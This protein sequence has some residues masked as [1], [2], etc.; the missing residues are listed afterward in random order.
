[1]REEDLARA[2]AEYLRRERFNLKRIEKNDLYYDNLILNNEI[3]NINKEYDYKVYK[4]RRIYDETHDE[5]RMPSR[6]TYYGPTTEEMEAARIR[7]M[8]DDT[9]VLNGSSP[10]Y[11]REDAGVI[12]TSITRNI[13]SIDYSWNDTDEV[14]QVAILEAK[15]QGYAFNHN[16]PQFMLNNPELVRLS[17]AKDIN[18]INF[19]PNDVITDELVLYAKELALKNNYV[20]SNDSPS[21]FKE[22]IEIIKQ[23]LRLN[24][25]INDYV[26]WYLL[27]PEQLT[28][29]ENYIIDNHLDY[30]ITYNSPFKS[31][32]D[33]CIISAKND[34]GSVNYFNWESLLKNKESGE[35]VVDTLIEQNYVLSNNSHYKL[36]EIPKL[37][38]SSIKNDIHSARYF[39][40]DIHDLLA[41]DLEELGNIEDKFGNDCRELIYEIRHYLIQNGFYSLEQIAK[42][43][44]P[45]L[46]DEVLLDYYLKQLGMPKDAE[47]EELKLFYDRVKDFFK[48][49][50]STP[51]RVSDTR[52]AFQMVAQKKWEDYRRE[53]ND[54]YT[55][56]FNRICDSLEKNNNFISALNE[57]KFLMK[58][59][60]VLDERK[61]AL[62]NAFIE[63]HQLYHS[64]NA[65][66]KMELLQAKRDDISK[67]AALFISKSKEDFIS[68]QMTLFD[69]KYKQFF[70]IRV[71]N[72]IVRKKVVEIKQR[73][74]LKKLFNSHDESLMQKLN[75]IKNKY[76]SYNYNAAISKDRIPQIIEQFISQ[77]IT[78][79]VSSVDDILAGS[80]P[81]RFDE[82]ENY[83]KVAKLINRL[84]SHNISYDG[85][86]VN[87]YR[88]FI[89]FD[90]QKYVYNGN[91]FNDNELAQIMGYKDLKY[92]FGKVRSEI[93]QIAKGIDKFDELTGEDIKSVIGE[94]P[95]TDEYYEFNP[96]IY[97]RFYLNFIDSFVQAF[98]DNKDVI[99][100][101]T[102]Y[103]ALQQL[104]HLNGLIHI[105]SMTELGYNDALHY[106]K[107][108]DAVF[109]DMKKYVSDDEVAAIIYNIPNLMNLLTPSEINIE[110]LDKLI[111]LNMLI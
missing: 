60:D 91:G 62:F 64:S 61:Y 12:I 56:I 47:D 94:C 40:K 8:Q 78:N 22:D 74:M 97:R 88:D 101:D 50:L 38:L 34:L 102:N 95:F 49:T 4:N 57:L 46:K 16:T 92:V 96:V 13:N 17:I 66:N 58:I 15:K 100:N 45:L 67:N 73:D 43:K 68:E 39:S 89:I 85:P 82:Y 31:N 28:D 9:Q 5:I 52:K 18:T 10:S 98:D 20:L 108:H 29:I 76:L 53:N 36:K 41:T 3:L 19:I 90:G 103:Q 71:D 105:S 48:T 26:I 70:T 55:N 111:C 83:E 81:A 65:E 79:N 84:N 27:T 25:N 86:E 14:Q 24:K 80:K 44:I 104:V 59:D 107:A 11:L 110:N 63:Y 54:Y 69:E 23:S 30:I 7:F 99:L 106:N 6:P 109:D 33:I 2:L 87:K 1:M 37:C 35:R 72:P 75:A 77:S 93:I 32:P 51:A 42:F 21:F